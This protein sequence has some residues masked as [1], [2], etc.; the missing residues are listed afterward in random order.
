MGS[1]SI[2]NEAEGIPARGIIAKYL[3]DFANRVPAKFSLEHWHQ[4]SVARKK[5][6]RGLGVL[7]GVS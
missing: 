6:N 3:C 5:K 4:A 2:G 7:L 1:E